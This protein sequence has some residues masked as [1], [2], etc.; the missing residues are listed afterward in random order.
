MRRTLH[1]LWILMVAALIPVL[2]WA[3]QGTSGLIVEEIASDSAAAK[4][5]LKLGD[6]IVSYDNRQ[7]SSPTAL[8]AAQENTFGKTEVVLAVRRG[9][10]LFKVPVPLGALG[11]QVRPE[12]SPDVDS[13]Y[14]QGRTALKS[15][16]EINEFGIA[17]LPEMDRD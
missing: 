12:L 14:E 8:E 10:E 16:S 9:E 11:V 5:G 15:R 7:L 2:S 17:I 1:L 4:A 13:L 6:R 3:Q